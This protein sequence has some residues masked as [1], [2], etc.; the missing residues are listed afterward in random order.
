MMISLSIC[1]DYKS[2]LA[3]R[4]IGLGPRLRFLNRNSIPTMR[5]TLRGT[6]AAIVATAM[7]VALTGLPITH[8]LASRPE[9]LS[10]RCRL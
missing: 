2:M 3:S 8:R 9:A 1:T 5:S 7:V 6:A 10:C 4:R